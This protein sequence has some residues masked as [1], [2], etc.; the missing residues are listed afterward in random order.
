MTFPTHVVL[1]VR[2]HEWD[3]KLFEYRDSEI[4]GTALLILPHM[5]LLEPL[6]R[7]MMHILCS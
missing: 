2:P 4:V 6:T 1:G 3:M 5:G 7:Y